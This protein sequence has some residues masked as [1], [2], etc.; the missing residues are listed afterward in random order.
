[1]EGLPFVFA[2]QKVLA[3]KFFCAR[4]IVELIRQLE[5]ALCPIDVCAGRMEMG[6]VQVEVEVRQLQ[7]D[8][9]YQP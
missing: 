2:V 6:L 5:I 9:T 8:P 4:Q 3:A 1:M 7:Y